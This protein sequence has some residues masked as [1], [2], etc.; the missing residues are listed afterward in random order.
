ACRADLGVRLQVHLD[1]RAG[2]DDGTDVAPFDHD[3]PL[4]RELALALAHHLADRVMARDHG[5]HPV[6]PR[7]ADGRRHVGAGDEDTADRVERDGIAE[8]ERAERLR[9]AARQPF[10][11]REPRQG[12]V[13]RPRVEVAEA[14]TL[15]ELA[16]DCALAGSRRSVDGNDHRLV[17]CSTRSW[18]P[19]KDTA[20]LSK[21][22][23]STPSRLASPATAPSIAMRWSP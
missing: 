16:R 18:K 2:R 8:R 4:A 19:G 21:P 3:V 13:H 22:R 5:H 17:T 12:A 14:E 23:T 10:V 15:G 1:L 7:L 20:T 9:L 6:D 11:Q